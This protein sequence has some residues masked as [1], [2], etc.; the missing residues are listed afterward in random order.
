[1]EVIRGGQGD[2]GQEIC[3]EAERR[4]AR[5][6]GGDDLRGQA[7]GTVADE[8]AH[9]A[10]GGRVGFTGTHAYFPFL[11]RPEPPAAPGGDRAIVDAVADRPR[12]ASTYH[13]YNIGKVLFLV[14]QKIEPKALLSLCRFTKLHA[15]RALPAPADRTKKL[16]MAAAAIPSFAARPSPTYISAALRTGLEDL[17]DPLRAR[18]DLRASLRLGRR[19]HESRA[20]KPGAGAS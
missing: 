17:F 14:L 4:G 13:T 1:M 19:R 11:V 16:D 7:S 3:G 6:A 2:F 15:V 9:P 5:T 20:A 12:R 18:R 10:E 8:G